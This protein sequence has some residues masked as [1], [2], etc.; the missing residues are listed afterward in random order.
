MSTIL[1]AVAAPFF[2]ILD[3]T[4]A[5]PVAAAGTLATMAATVA[6]AAFFLS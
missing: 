4:L 1:E 2:A 6:A 5:A 3:F